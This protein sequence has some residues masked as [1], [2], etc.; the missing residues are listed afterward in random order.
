MKHWRAGIKVVQYLKATIIH[1]IQFDSNLQL[2]S[3]SDSDWASDIYDRQSVSG[4]LVM[5]HGAPV[6]FKSKTQKSVALKT[7]EA[8]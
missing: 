7:A 4:V 1:G 6:I 8:E 3:Y 2:C 5:Y